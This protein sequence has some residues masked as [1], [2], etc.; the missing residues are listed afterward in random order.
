MSPDPSLPP[1]PER[2]AAAQDLAWMARVKQ[3]DETALQA[4]IEAHQHRIIGTVAKMLGDSGDAE[5]IAQQV[6]IRVW[7]SAA[8]YE[9]TAKFTTWLFKITR[10]LVFNELRRR[11]RHPAQ[12][13]DAAAFHDDDRPMQVADHTVKAPDTSVLDEEMQAAIQ[14]AIDELPETQ[15][16]AVILRRYD[17]IPYEEIGEILD[18]SVPAVKS[19]L[20]RARTEL[21]EKL[22]RY[23]DA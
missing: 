11:K 7:K 21:R 3:G 15:R 12:S 6:F 4:L 17:D 9:P 8:R 13:L 18:L 16:M 2:D 10:N 22:K 14:R 1:N 5:D 23:L 20:F 19:V